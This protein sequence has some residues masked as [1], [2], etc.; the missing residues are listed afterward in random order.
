MTVATPIK[1]LS[2]AIP[3]R[4]AV[5]D[6]TAEPTFVQIASPMPMAS[7]DRAL[8]VLRDDHSKHVSGPVFPCPECFLPPLTQGR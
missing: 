1:R 6:P 3:A 2:F 5:P 4:P 8:M 7:L